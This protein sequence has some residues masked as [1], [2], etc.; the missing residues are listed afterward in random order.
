M[1]PDDRSTSFTFHKDSLDYNNRVLRSSRRKLQDRFESDSNVSGNKKMSKNRRILSNISLSDPR[2]ALRNG[3]DKI[4][5][6]LTNVKISIGTFSQVKK[7]HITLINPRQ[8]ID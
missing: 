4:S 8:I 5:K 2:Q 3:A 7:K 1:K 6:T